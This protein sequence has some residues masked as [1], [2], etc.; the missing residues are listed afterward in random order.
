VIAV[1]QEST[2]NRP[3][4]EREG[5]VGWRAAVPGSRDLYLALFNTRD[6]GEGQAAAGVPVSVTLGELGLSGR[7]AVRD[8]WQGRDL[9]PVEEALAPVVAWHGAAL[10]RLSPLDSPR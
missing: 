8:L 5:L 3:L 6:R 10:Y 2:G 9:A 4:F 1:D 7:C